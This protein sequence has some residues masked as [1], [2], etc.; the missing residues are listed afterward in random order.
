[1]P[2]IETGI[3]DRPRAHGATGSEWVS[4][5][6]PFVRIAHWVLVAAFATAYLSEDAL[7]LHVPAGYLLGATLALRIVW[8]FTGPRHAR[9]A[10]FLCRP[11][12]ALRYLHDL[13]RGRAVRYLGHSPAGAMMIVLLILGLAS[14]TVS[15][16]AL[17]AAEENAGPLAVWLGDAQGDAGQG[18]AVSE[19]H[20]GGRSTANEA[21]ARYWEELHELSANFTLLLVVLHIGGVAWAS[22]AHQENLVLAMIT[23]RKRRE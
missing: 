5:W 19:G 1:M 20:G 22:R 8:G 4:V 15:G 2:S 9:F 6:D 21:A 13:L 23:G 17:Y 3:A 11:E 18:A 7:D 12:T 14:T 10:D 16:I